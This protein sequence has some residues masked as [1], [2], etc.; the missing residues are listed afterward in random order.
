MDALLGM[1]ELS[2][3]TVAAFGAGARHFPK[4]EELVS[5]VQ[6]CWRPETPC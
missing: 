4:I 2:A 1:G 6:V 3:Y 5:E